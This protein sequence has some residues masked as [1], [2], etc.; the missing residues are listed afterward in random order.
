MEGFAIQYWPSHIRD[1]AE[2]AM[3]VAV[4]FELAR[5]FHGERG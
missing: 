4:I 2:T 1:V 3:T 5:G